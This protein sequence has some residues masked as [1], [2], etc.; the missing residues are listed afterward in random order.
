MSKEDL[1][2][3]DP[4]PTTEIQ[5]VRPKVEQD[6]LFVEPENTNKEFVAVNHRVRGGTKT[7]FFVQK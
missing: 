4:I 5:A 7:Y 2:R 6:V 3:P 1:V